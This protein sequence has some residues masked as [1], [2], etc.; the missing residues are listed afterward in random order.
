[1]KQYAHLITAKANI[2]TENFLLH[3]FIKYQMENFLKN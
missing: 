1:M 2:N 3:F